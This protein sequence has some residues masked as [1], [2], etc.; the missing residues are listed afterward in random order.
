MT[1]LLIIIFF[2]GQELRQ[3]HQRI[4]IQINQTDLN[5]RNSF[6]AFRF[7]LLLFLS[8]LVISIHLLSRFKFNTTIFI[9]ILCLTFEIWMLFL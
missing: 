1:S 2:Q 9:P 7:F 6:Y 5:G 8:D 3:F 4:L